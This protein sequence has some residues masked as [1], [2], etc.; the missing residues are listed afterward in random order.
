MLARDLRTF[1]SDAAIRKGFEYFCQELG[2][3]VLAKN[4]GVVVDLNI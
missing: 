4:I 1:T 2:E 3:R